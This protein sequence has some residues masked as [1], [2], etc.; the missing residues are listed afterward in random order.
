MSDEV[1]VNFKVGRSAVINVKNYE[2]IKP[3]VEVEVLNIPVTSV[4][5][6]YAKVSEVLDS[7]FQ[8]E[9]ANLYCEI[10]SIRNSGI[11]DHISS[12]VNQDFDTV[13]NN[14]KMFLSSIEENVKK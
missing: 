4:D 5:S 3:F 13:R 14:I 11:E 8:L 7:L 6:V 10:K 9:E 1:M 12:I 2:S